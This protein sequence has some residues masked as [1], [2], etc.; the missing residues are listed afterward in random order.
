MTLRPFEASDLALCRAIFD[1][2]TPKFFAKTEREEFEAFL[3]NLPGPYSILEDN[4]VIV[5]CGG[6]AKHRDARD[7]AVLCWGMIDQSRHRHRWGTELLR[8]RL[9]QVHAAGYQTVEMSTSQHSFDFFR[10][11]G[12]EERRRIAN[13]YAPGIDLIELRLRLTIE[14][15]EAP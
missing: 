15:G 9:E 4:G 13:G 2:N 1:S 12:F 10:K 7:V 3:N 8:R 6:W 14:L 11:F 5:G